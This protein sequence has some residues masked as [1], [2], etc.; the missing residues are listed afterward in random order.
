MEVNLNFDLFKIKIL[1]QMRGYYVIVLLSLIFTL[2]ISINS[3]TCY[4]ESNSYSGVAS[5]TRVS[6]KTAMNVTIL[7]GTLTPA[8][9]AAA[10]K[11][12]TNNKTG[13]STFGALLGH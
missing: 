7:N 5:G 11:S 10:I 13:D 3:I 12:C 1:K 9:R 6:D 2:V 4:D 8:F